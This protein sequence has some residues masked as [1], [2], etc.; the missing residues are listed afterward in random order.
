MGT[1]IVTFTD[2]TDTYTDNAVWSIIESLLL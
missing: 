2:A 1:S